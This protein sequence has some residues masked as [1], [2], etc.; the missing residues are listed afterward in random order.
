MKHFGHDHGPHE[1]PHHHRHG[2]EPFGLPPRGGHHGRGGRGGQGRFF[3]A[4]DLRYLILHCISTTPRHG[5]EIIKLI[6]SQ[7]AGAHAPSPGIVYPTLTML[8]EMGLA[9]VTVDGT[10]KLYTIT[11]EGRRA[12]AE[13]LD[14]VQAMITRMRIAGERQT[15]ERPL[16]IM[17]AMENL[18][19]V[20]QMRAA[21]LTGTRMDAV[22]DIIDHAAKA[23][24]RL[25]A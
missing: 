18:R 23:I 3:D 13:K 14:Q 24:E 7:S 1:H 6:E 19:L 25:P 4:A 16:P 12:L 11:E 20:L 15:Q 21:D 10:R 8:E 17:R 9:A 5:Y 2:D 22:T